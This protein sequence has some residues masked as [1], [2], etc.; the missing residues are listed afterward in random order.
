MRLT[1][2]VLRGRGA[3]G[4]RSKHQIA[5][6]QSSV[7]EVSGRQGGPQDRAPQGPERAQEP[8]DKVKT[9]AQDQGPWR[10]AR[11][12]PAPARSLKSPR[13]VKPQPRRIA[14]V[15]QKFYKVKKQFCRLGRV[16]F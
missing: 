11:A 16:F 12:F 3:E 13:K 8:A 10:A 15:I 2:R 1:V 7:R 6:D 14:K 5:Q 4:A 9:K